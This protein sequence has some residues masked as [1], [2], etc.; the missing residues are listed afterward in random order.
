MWTKDCMDAKRRP[1][2][3]TH[4]LPASCAQVMGFA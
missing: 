2:A 1:D 4:R 3:E